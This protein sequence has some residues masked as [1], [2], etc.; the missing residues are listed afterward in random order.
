MNDDYDEPDMDDMINDYIADQE[1]GPPEYDEFDDAPD[2]Y[3]FE[4]KDPVNSNNNNNVV[5]GDA[6]A[7]NDTVDDDED[8]VP[9]VISTD[10]TS[11]F[12][13]P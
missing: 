3:D 12:H 1:E 7:N 9:K 2:P 8:D 5:M 10:A 11:R 13:Q 6:A 4:E